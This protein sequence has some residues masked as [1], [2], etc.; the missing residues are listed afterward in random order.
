MSDDDWICK[1]C[2]KEIEGSAIKIEGNRYHNECFKCAK[3]EENFL[4][5]GNKNV[6]I[7]KGLCVPPLL[8]PPLFSVSLFPKDPKIERIGSCPTLCF[9]TFLFLRTIVQ[10]TLTFPR[11]TLLCRV[12]RCAWQCNPCRRRRSTKTQICRSSSLL[13]WVLSPLFYDAIC[14][15]PDWFH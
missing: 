8:V 6:T 9:R 11:Q 2:K 12:L 5:T 7:Q 1:A 10:L 15:V 4:E 13:R 3:C 14:F